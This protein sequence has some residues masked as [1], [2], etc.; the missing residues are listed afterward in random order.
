MEAGW[1]MTPQEYYNLKASKI[2][3]AVLAALEKN[4]QRKFSQAEVFFFEKWWQS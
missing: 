1:K 2:F 3:P 4:T